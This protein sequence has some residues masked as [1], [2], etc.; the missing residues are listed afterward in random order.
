MARPSGNSINASARPTAVRPA[1]L[2]ATVLC[3]IVG[4]FGLSGCLFQPREAQPPGGGSNWVSPDRPDKVLKNMQTGLE[5][6]SGG[7]YEKSIGEEFTFVPLAGDEANFPG[8]E[9]DNWTRAVEIDSIK[10]LLGQAS[11]IALEFSG[12]TPL[13]SSGDVSKYQ[14]VYKL[15]VTYS[16]T[17]SAPET[18]QAKANF[19][20][21]LGSKGYVLIRWEDIEVVEGATWGFLRGV[22]RGQ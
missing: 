2:Q 5:G 1:A 15:T 11:K 19:D 10:K 14:A 9:L 13:S 22:L 6:L 8:G 12:V 17:P 18:Y 4:A 7:N 20:F 21:K 3:L 16:S